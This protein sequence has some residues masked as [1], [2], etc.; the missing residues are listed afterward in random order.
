MRFRQTIER[1]LSLLDEAFEAMDVRGARELAGAD[2]F[3][4]YDTFGFPLDL[5]QVIC[6]ERGYTV[7][8]AGYDAALDEARKKSEFKGMAEA[9]EGVYR[10]A[11][12]KLGAGAV[13]FSGYERDSDTSKL[14]ALVKDGALADSA[15]A[16]ATVEL[17]CERT[18]FYGESGGQ[19]GDG[20]VI[21]RPQRAR[22]HR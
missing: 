10:E 11:L 17:I 8:A 12:P 7:D 5:T 19:I 22:A 14:V 6:A 1:G 18:P 15:E 3:Q 13:V 20:G 2:A 4:L 21:V 16:G 9:V